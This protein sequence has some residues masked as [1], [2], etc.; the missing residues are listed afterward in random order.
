[1]VISGLVVH[2]DILKG[3]NL[4]GVTYYFLSSISL[5]AVAST[6]EA[7]TLARYQN[8]F[9]VPLRCFLLQAAKQLQLFCDDAAGRRLLECFHCKENLGVLLVIKARKIRSQSKS[10][11]TFGL[12]TS[13]YF[14]FSYIGALLLPAFSFCPGASWVV[15]ASA[16][17][18]AL[19][20]RTGGVPSAREC[21]AGENPQRSARRWGRTHRC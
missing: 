17:W 3:H 9:Y 4:E 15:G 12:F 5:E 1:M 10:Q 19:G 18:A 16:A 13:I 2:K 6:V 20:E 14:F 7:T 8:I 21:A 11:S